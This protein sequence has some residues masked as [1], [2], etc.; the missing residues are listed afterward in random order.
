ML[1]RMSESDDSTTL[2]CEYCGTLPAPV[3][4]QRSE[5]SPYTGALTSGYVG[6][7]HA[8]DCPYYS[9]PPQPVE[10][11]GPGLAGVSRRRGRRARRG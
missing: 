2:W 9:F 1:V 4:L 8:V 7:D 5:A 6:P 10:V 3:R 11:A